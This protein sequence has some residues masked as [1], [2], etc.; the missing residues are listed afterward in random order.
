MTELLK[1][2]DKVPLLIVNLVNEGA[3]TAAGGC[4]FGVGVGSGFSVPSSSSAPVSKLLI[5]SSKTTSFSL[6]VKLALFITQ[7]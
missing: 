6:I 7:F 4:G 3:G 5:S 1:V 2:G